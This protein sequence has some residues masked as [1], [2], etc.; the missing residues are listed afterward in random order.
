MNV[1]DGTT[2]DVNRATGVFGVALSATAEVY[3]ASAN[4]PAVQAG[5]QRCNAA[6]SS[7]SNISNISGNYWMRGGAADTLFNTV[8]TP[9]SQVNPWSW[10]SA[11][12]TPNGEC[13]FAKAG[14]NHPGGVNI[15][16]A[17]GSVRFAKDSI[18]Q[19]TWWGLGTKASGEVISSDSY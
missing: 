7:G 18:N 4:W 13:E 8:V 3:D 6:Y 11:A 1:G 14:S 5:M 10:C 12:A 19:V 15:L 16:M 9:N 2:A 17:D